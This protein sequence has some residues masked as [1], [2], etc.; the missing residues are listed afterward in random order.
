[1]GIGGQWVKEEQWE[2]GKGEENGN[3]CMRAAVVTKLIDSQTITCLE[4]QVFHKL[5]P[6]GEEEKNAE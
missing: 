1:M 3:G 5:Y 4:G 6:I 2:G